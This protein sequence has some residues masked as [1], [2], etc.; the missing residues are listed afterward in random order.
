MFRKHS[1]TE[2]SLLLEY[3]FKLYPQ[4]KKTKVK[5]ILKFGSVRVNDRVVTLHRHR[6]KP[7]DSVEVL[8][9]KN[10]FLERLKTEFS[11]KMVYEDE[12]LIVVEKP[13]GLLTMATEKEKEN[14]LYFEL[15]EYE[16]AR[17]KT[18]HGR[19]FIVHRLDRDSSGLVVFAKTEDAKHALQENWSKTIKKYYA[20]TEGVP[21]E[22]DGLIEGYLAEDSF[23]RVYSVSKLS[24]TSKPALTRYRVLRDN[25]R[26]ALLDTSLETGRK[27]Q[28]R[29]HLSD[30]GHPIAGDM[31]YGAQTDP[32]RR[33][34]L[35]S[36][37]LAFPHPSTG[38]L[39]TFIS[40][41]PENFEKLVG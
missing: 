33:L 18:K 22:K 23:R 27:N 25:G 3:L 4:Y 8:S 13:S 40:K 29:V 39:K 21:K 10:T 35:H 6:L 38:E 11:F 9:E 19:I 7:G 2:P 34:A 17:S 26:Y 16:R 30:L 5:Q 32:I 1:V 24:K 15:T 31:K 14:T 36:Y 41:L 12:D 20:V 28:I 37:L